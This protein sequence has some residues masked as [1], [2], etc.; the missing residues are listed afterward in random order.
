M[1]KKTARKRAG[2]RKETRARKDSKRKPKRA[3]LPAAIRKNA[4]ALRAL[5]RDHVKRGAIRLGE[6]GWLTPTGSITGRSGGFGAVG[7]A[8]EAIRALPGDRKL[9]SFD[10]IIRWNGPRGKKM[11]ETLSRIGVPMDYA[12]TRGDLTDKVRSIIHDAIFR[13]VIPKTLGKYPS[14]DKTE[15]MTPEQFAKM[16]RDVKQ[17]RGLS[18]KTVF[19]REVTGH[20]G[21][22]TAAPEKKKT[23]ARAGQRGRRERK[24][25]PLRGSSS[26]RKLERGNKGTGAKLPSRPR[27]QAKRKK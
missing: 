3:S 5:G 15:K 18:F 27:A 24:P 25:V 6:T 16:I 21:D 12:G 19:Y 10:L 2:A 22:E 20:E 13:E 9:F 8:L 14:Q 1:K 4:E 17:A 7:R 11:Q 23:R 26:V